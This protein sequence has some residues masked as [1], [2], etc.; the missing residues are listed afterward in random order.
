MRYRK[1]LTIDGDEEYAIDAL[2]DTMLK[3]DLLTEKQYEEVSVATNAAE[4]I[5]TVYSRR[6]RDR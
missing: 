2:A 4:T 6:S 3:L 5:N 1:V